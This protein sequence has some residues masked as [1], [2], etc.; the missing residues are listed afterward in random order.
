M[1]NPLT[2]NEIKSILNNKVKI[3][4][5]GQINDYNNI[6]E[7]LSPYNR[8]IILYVWSKTEDNNP[9]GHW[10]LVFRNKNNNIEVFDSFGSWIDSFLDKIDKKFRAETGQS[11]KS[12]TKL[13]L[14][15]NKK[16]EYNDKKLQNDNS[17]TCGKWCCYR[18][19]KSD[20]DID[21]FN[22]LFGSNT[23]N[24]DKLI[25]KIFSN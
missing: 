4:Q 16:I 25:L 7:L 12:L 13:L 11:Y 3:I 6:D 5:Y 19:I 18:L 10:Q 8:T 15:S 24:N 2:G 1:D 20:L 22:N 23:I 17:N 9:F 21:E 14:N